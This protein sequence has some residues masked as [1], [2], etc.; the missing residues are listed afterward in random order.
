MG[1]GYWGREGMVR[2]S[3]EVVT[4]WQGNGMEI[5]RNGKGMVNE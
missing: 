4:G 1:E 2:K 5:V 3:K